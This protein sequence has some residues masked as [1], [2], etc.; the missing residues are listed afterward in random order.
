[1]WR[2]SIIIG[3]GAWVLG[4]LLMAAVIVKLRQVDSVTVTKHHDAR[5]GVTCYYAE[6]GGGA[7]LFCMPDNTITPVGERSYE[8]VVRD[9]L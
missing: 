6:G 3:A 2:R 5:G 1:M 8:D 9:Y 7:A 4:G